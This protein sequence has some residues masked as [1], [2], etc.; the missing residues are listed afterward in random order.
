M[1][2]T[3]SSDSGSLDRIFDLALTGRQ[4]MLVLAVLG[5]YETEYEWE[6]QDTTLE[7]LATTKRMIRAEIDEQTDRTSGRASVTA[8]LNDALR[9]EV[10][11]R[12]L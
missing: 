2:K 6:R 4:V 5:I 3:A 1:S 8:G 12:K 7:L 10:E 11:E 9:R